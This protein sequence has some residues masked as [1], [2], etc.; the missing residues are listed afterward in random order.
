M[1]V[2]RSRQE[3]TFVRTGTSWGP[4]ET[5]GMYSESFK[6]LGNRRVV[7]QKTKALLPSAP[8]T[9]L[10]GIRATRNDSRDLSHTLL[11]STAF[12]SKV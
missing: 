3:H 5:S 12:L 7:P 11:L 6:I 4:C 10:L 8:A 9:P 2:L 1:A